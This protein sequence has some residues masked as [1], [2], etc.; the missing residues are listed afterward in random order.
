MQ[1][2]HEAPPHEGRLHQAELALLSSQGRW[3]G[4]G[5]RFLGTAS[6]CAF[7]A[8]LQRARARA[9]VCAYISFVR[10]VPVPPRLAPAAAS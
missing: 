1:R 10:F 9:R 3:G 6:G 2:L 8:G 4:S 7:P 5:S